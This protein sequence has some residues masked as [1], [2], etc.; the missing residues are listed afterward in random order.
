MGSLTSERVERRR[1]GTGGGSLVRPPMGLDGKGT[2]ARQKGGQKGLVTPHSLIITDFP[3]DRHS[4]L[5]PSYLLGECRG[6]V[7]WPRRVAIAISKLS[8]MRRA[9]SMN[10]AAAPGGQTSE[11]DCSKSA[12]QRSKW[13][14]P[15]ES[16][17]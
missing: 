6:P 2:L 9:F 14:G 7:I 10:T 12:S 4:G 3:A 8:A 17:M 11:V 16:G 5:Q 1:G 15:I 13:W